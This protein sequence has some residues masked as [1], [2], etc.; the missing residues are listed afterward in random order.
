MAGIQIDGVNN[1]IDFDDDAD[2]SISSATDDTLVIE[3][4]GSTLATATATSLTI[5]DGV[6]ITTADNTDILSLIS[7]DTDDNSGPNLRMYRNSSSPADNDV[8]G[9]IQFEG[10]N[11]AA[12]DVVYNDISMKIQDAS[13]GSED[14]IIRIRNMQAGTLRQYYT[15]G[16]TEAVIN[17]D[18]RDIN[19][20]VEGSSNTHSFFVDAGNDC[21]LINAS[22]RSGDARIEASS[23]SNQRMLNLDCSNTG[24]TSNMLG[25]IAARA[26][27]GVYNFIQCMS[28]STSGQ[29]NEFVVAGDGDIFA[30]GTYTANGADYAEFFETNDGNA[31]DVGKTIVLDGNKVRASTSSDDA[32]TIIGVVRPKVDGINSMMIGNTAWNSWTNK[33][34]HDDYGRFI[35][36]DYTVTEWETSV[37]TDGVKNTLSYETDKI[38][39]DV[40]APSD[41]TVKTQQRKKLNP[42]YDESKEYKPRSERDEWVIIGM[43]GQIQVEKGQKTGTN[44]IKMRDISETV[45]EWLVR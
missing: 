6:T 7:T 14:G 30:D 44:G 25:L 42:D 43:L 40:T 21:V 35:M 38:P 23:S 18:S 13:D 17:D 22:A 29:D 5:N 4:G 11:D 3:V 1:K 8:I 19:F 2:T 41:A 36:E 39:S 12:E 26:G 45:E 32:S 28:D 33:Y 37:S 9:Q 27:T 34:M 16:G 10:K 24:N 20:R 31:I 15:V